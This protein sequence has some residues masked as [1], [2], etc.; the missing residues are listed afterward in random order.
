M[1]YLITDDSRMARKM[2]NKVLTEFVGEDV[3][4]IQATNGEEAVELYKKHKPDLCFMDLTMPVMDGYEATL[5]ITQF[6]ENAQVMVISA[7]VQQGALDKA[8]KNGALGFINKPI[9][10]D[11]MKNILT[12]LGHI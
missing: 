9:D 12:K 5:Q 2:L 4:V 11:K 1:T 6:D 10:S 8:R 7:D 3:N